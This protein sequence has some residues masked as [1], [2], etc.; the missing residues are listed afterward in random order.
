MVMI[1]A[2][3]LRDGDRD[4]IAEWFRR[5][6][7]RL[8]A[9]AAR[10]VSPHDAEDVVHDAFVSTLRDGRGF[11]GDAAPSTWIYR[12]TTNAALMHLRKRRRRP[13]ESLD[14]LPADVVAG[15]VGDAAHRPEPELR[16][17][18]ADAARALEPVLGKLTALDRRILHLRLVEE[19][20]TEATARSVGLSVAATK[21][22]L[23]RAR[24]ALRALLGDSSADF[25]KAAV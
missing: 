2:N 12:V 9:L 25:A 14:A 5:D 11:R 10:I 21:T 4:S 17:G 23:S 22:R 6:R 7:K 15:L 13:A 19:L 16:L 20:T 8:L 24:A 3:A 18:R 1:T